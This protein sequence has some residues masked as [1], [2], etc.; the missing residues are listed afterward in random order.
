MLCFVS[1][2]SCVRYQWAERRALRLSGSVCDV[3]TWNEIMKAK[4]LNMSTDVMWRYKMSYEDG[5][6]WCHVPLCSHFT[7]LDVFTRFLHLCRVVSV[8]PPASGQKTK[9]LSLNRL[10][11]EFVPA[12]HMNLFV[13]K[14]SLQDVFLTPTSQ[15]EPSHSETQETPQIWFWQNLVVQLKSDSVLRDTRR[16]PDTFWQTPGTNFT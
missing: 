4:T 2:S 3:W 10:P 9:T 11:A 15:Q 13:S 14:S 16:P 7:R 6:V 5:S 12:L 1:S 8:T